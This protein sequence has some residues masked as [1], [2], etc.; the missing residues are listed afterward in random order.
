MSKN[1]TFFCTDAAS[2]GAGQT[3]EAPTAQAAL[4][5]YIADAWANP[6]DYNQGEDGVDAKIKAWV[7]D[8]QEILL[9]GWIDFNAPTS[10]EAAS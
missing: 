10:W 2:G 7:A 1:T 3:I 4:R 8:D 9:E 5:E 6:S